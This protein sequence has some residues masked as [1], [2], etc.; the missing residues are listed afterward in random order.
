MR[1]SGKIVRIRIRILFEKF[2][3]IRIR[4]GSD[5]FQKIVMG[6]HKIQIFSRTDIAIASKLLYFGNLFGYKWNLAQN[7]NKNWFFCDSENKI[8]EISWFSWKSYGSGERIRI[9]KDPSILT[10]PDPDPFGQKSTD[11]DPDPGPRNP[12][13]RVTYICCYSPSHTYQLSFWFKKLILLILYYL[14]VKLCQ[15]ILFSTK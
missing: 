4:N 5:Q 6:S 7:N 12:G 2:L 10:D 8:E 14:M 15:I 1:G 11:P 13:L 3:R 9:R